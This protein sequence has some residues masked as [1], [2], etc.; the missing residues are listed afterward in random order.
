MHGAEQR[1]WRISIIGSGDN[2]KEWLDP[3][4]QHLVTATIEIGRQPLQVYTTWASVSLTPCSLS[5]RIHQE[6]WY[7]PYIR[8]RLGIKGFTL[9]KLS[10]LCYVRTKIHRG[11]DIDGDHCLVV[12]KIKLKWKKKTKIGM[13]WI[14]LKELR[15]EEVQGSVHQGTCWVLWAEKQAAD[16]CAWG[17]RWKDFQGCS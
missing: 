17:R 13:K 16:V 15:E 6:T 10:H 5:N 2:Y 8:V 11:A 14:H 1:W 3:I 12:C 4:T 9:M 7:P